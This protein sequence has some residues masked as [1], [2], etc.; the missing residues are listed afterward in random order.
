MRPPAADGDAKWRAQRSRSSSTKGLGDELPYP[1]ASFDRVLSSLMFH[2][3]PTG[4]KG[5]T[6]R[7][8]RRVLKPGGTNWATE[9]TVTRNVYGHPS[10]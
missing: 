9:A 1:D 4:E 8:V 7:A 5:K 10:R 3:L 2:H 6:L